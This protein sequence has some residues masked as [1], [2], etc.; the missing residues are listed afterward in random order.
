MHP[1]SG[2]E[3]GLYAEGHDVTG[4][5]QTGTGKTIAFLLTILND[6]LSNPKDDRYIAEPRAL[7][8]APTRELAI[9]IAA[10]ADD[11]TRFCD[12]HVVTLVGG[13]EYQ[14]QLSALEK[15]T[16]GYCCCDT[17]QTS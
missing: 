8:V 17:R 14:K 6:L 16:R 4:R 15:R 5:A 10:D 2:S 9:Q 11:L 7:I 3:F 13:E 12:I 1:Y